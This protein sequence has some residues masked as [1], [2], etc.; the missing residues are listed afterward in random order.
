[1]CIYYHQKKKKTSA[2]ERSLIAEHSSINIDCANNYKHSRF[3]VINYCS[4]LT[5]L[6]RLKDLSVF[7]NKSKLC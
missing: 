6:V 3:S 2:M 7:L 1:M 5:D 4:N